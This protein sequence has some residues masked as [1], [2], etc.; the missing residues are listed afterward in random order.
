MTEAFVVTAVIVTF[1]VVAARVILI[2]TRNP[3]PLME[4]GDKR[5][6]EIKKVKTRTLI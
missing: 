3:R 1:L 4:N 2:S 6:S 5:F